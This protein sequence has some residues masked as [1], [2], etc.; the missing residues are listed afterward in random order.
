[1]QFGAQIVYI[2]SNTAYGAYAQAAEQIGVDQTN[3]FVFGAM[4]EGLR[5]LLFDG[6]GTVARL[7]QPDGITPSR[8]AE[9]L[10]VDKAGPNVRC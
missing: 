5:Q 1:M 2:Q 6:L 3:D 10:E 7:G 4:H 9:M 8:M